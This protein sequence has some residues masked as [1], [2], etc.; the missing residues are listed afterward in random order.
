MLKHQF[1]ST[2]NV[3]YSQLAYFHLASFCMQHYLALPTLLF[4][5]YENKY[6][7][8]D[9]VTKAPDCFKTFF[10]INEKEFNERDK[11][12]NAGKQR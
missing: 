3:F 10:Q 1:H 5:K 9:N 2:Q 8:Q 6:K 11:V 12:E 4:N 7:L